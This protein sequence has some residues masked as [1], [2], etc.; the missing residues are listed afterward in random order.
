MILQVSFDSFR[1]FDNIPCNESGTQI[2][3][4]KL[5]EKIRQQEAINGSLFD[6]A[7]SLSN[8][9]QQVDKSLMYW[10]DYSGSFGWQI[11]HHPNEKGGKNMFE[12]TLKDVPEIYN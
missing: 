11:Y 2:E 12:R 6:I 8:D 5:I 7:T 3:N 10:E 4:N 9:G 1:F